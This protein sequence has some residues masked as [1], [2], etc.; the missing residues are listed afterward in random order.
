[1][2]TAHAIESFD[3]PFNRDLPCAFRAPVGTGKIKSSC[4]DFR[5]EEK[6]S[7]EPGGMGEHL[8]VQVEKRNQNTDQVARILARTGGVPRRDVRYA[9][10][11]DKNAVTIQWFSIRLPKIE[12]SAW[13]SLANDSV[14]I[15]DYQRHTRKL[16]IGSI[17]E[18]SFRIIIR[19][20]QCDRQLL[21]ERLGLIVRTGVPNYV[22]PQRF[23]LEGR[24][25][26]EAAA[27]LR[28]E[29]RIKDRHK[30]SLLLS[31]A[32]SF[33]FNQILADRVVAETWNKAIAGDAF[34]FDGSR[35]FFRTETVCDDLRSRVSGGEIHPTGVLWGSGESSVSADALTLE[36][37]SIQE[38]AELC[39]GLE[40]FG[41]KTGRRAL[42]LFANDLC[43]QF[44][45]KNTL[46]LSFSLPAGGYA[47][48][49]LREILDVD[50]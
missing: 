41:V 24:N 22:G 26:Y 47:T 6:L 12:D 15:L 30:R 19:D 45:E 20:L 37:K 48:T 17:S 44:C 32:R 16:K 7:F 27:F 2:K 38:N 39:R 14:K 34:V 40:S 49:V 46:A 33:V 36:T 31:T 28:G 3:K 43:W 23:G 10:L 13:Y 50:G 5:V 18:N 29:R 42:R 21:I 9:G 1:M 25:V 11:K 8:F 4:E 35:S